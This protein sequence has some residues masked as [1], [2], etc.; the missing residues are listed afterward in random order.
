VRQK[1]TGKDA[2]EF[3]TMLSFAMPGTVIGVA[4]IMAFN[5]PP[6]ELTAPA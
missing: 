4:Y 6:I 1:F 3:A 2:F 5:F